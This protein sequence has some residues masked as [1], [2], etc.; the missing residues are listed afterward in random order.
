MFSL[1]VVFRLSQHPGL[2]ALCV[3]ESGLETE[4]VDLI[5]DPLLKR[6]WAWVAALSSAPSSMASHPWLA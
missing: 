4:N 3:E 5:L 1:G 2:I 6:K